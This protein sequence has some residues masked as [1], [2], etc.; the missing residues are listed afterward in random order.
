MSAA[1]RLA[2]CAAL[3]FGLAGCPGSSV[4]P[5]AAA[6]ADAAAPPPATCHALRACVD[7]CGTDGRCAQRCEAVATPEARAPFDAVRSCT[8]KLCAAD[9]IPCICGAECY[10]S[11]PCF[12]TLET[13]L[14]GADDSFCNDYCH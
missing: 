9:D 5:D 1:G 8:A 4:R 3:V 12:E 7:R 6:V 13:C 14:Q 11:G 10:A 2:L